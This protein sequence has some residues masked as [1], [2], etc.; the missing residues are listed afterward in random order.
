MKI[1]ILSTFGNYG[2]AATCAK[3][4]Y[5]SLKKDGL[6]VELRAV[7]FYDNNLIKSVLPD[8][9]LNRIISK[10]YF[11]IERLQVLYNIKKIKHLYKFSTGSVGLK[12]SNF[13]IVKEADIIHLHWINFGLVS[14]AEIAELANKKCLIWT[15]HDMW[16]FTGGCHY[17]M[18]CERYKNVCD[19][20]FYLRNS[21]LSESVQDSK[22]SNWKPQAFKVI[23]TSNWLAQCTQN[24]TVFRG[25]N[26]EVLPTPIDVSIFKPLN[27]QELRKKYTLEEE[28]F[29]ILFVA[30]DIKD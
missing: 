15:Q 27:K 9:F 22:I 14:I 5:N 28:D 4:L 10:F 7:Q 1:L 19:D 16:S 29:Y 24:S 20:C 8:T 30:V 13:P 2:G 6:D 25:W 17:A 21:A 3:R 26:V 11:I 12:L 18:Q 23:A